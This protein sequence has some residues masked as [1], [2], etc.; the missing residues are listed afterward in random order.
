MSGMNVKESILKNQL[1]LLRHKRRRIQQQLKELK[2]KRSRK[3]LKPNKKEVVKNGKRKVVSDFYK[4]RLDRGR[5]SRKFK[6]K[7]NVYTVNFRA[8]PSDSNFVRRLLSQMLKEVKERMQC[9]PN[10]Y[11][12]LNIRHPSLDSDV[13]YEF[14]QSKNLNESTILT[15]IEGVQQS[16]KE[17]TITD[18]SAEF[19]L[20]HVKYPQGSG[21]QSAKHLHSNKVMFKRRKRS[22]LKI[23]NGNDSLCLPRAIVVAR[24][25]SQKPQDNMKLGEWKKKWDRIKRIDVLSPQ[26]KKEAL[27]LMKLANCDPDLPCGPAEWDKLQNI[28]APEYRLK[29]FQFKACSRLKLE[30]MY[31][32]KGDGVCLN[33]LLDK[34]HY[35][36]ILSM[37][38][39]T[40][41][42]Y[43]CN[44]CD[45][46]YAHIEDHRVKCPH[47]C[48]FCLADCPCP[49]DGSSIHC[50]QC[51]GYFKSRNCYQRH[52]QTYSNKT[53]ANVCSLMDRCPDCQTWMSKKLLAHHKCGQNK[54]CRICRK[55]VDREHQCF[56]QVKSVPK[57]RKQLQ[58]YIYFDFECTQENGIHVPNLCVAHRVCQ[59][60]DHLPVDQTCSHCDF[61]GGRRHLFRG[62]DTLTQFMEWLFQSQTHPTQKNQC[63]LLHKDAIVIAHNFKGYDGQ[64]ILN[65]LV[66]TSCVTP[67]VIMNGTKILSMQVL[68]LKFIDSYNYL[69]F[70]LSKMPSAFGFEELK[71][72]YFPHFFNT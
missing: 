19:E 52:L 72:G 41:N 34:D 66:H 36:T 12:R 49:A 22:L 2:E 5:K 47:L 42:P 45:V 33:I 3:E 7:Q 54:W 8:L 50:S 1:L 62:S 56:V 6:V 67:T 38:G 16:K 28:L 71:K 69:P 32:G 37:P 24:L 51:N 13:W 39:L 29:I 55:M 57:E 27:E 64:F 10:D 11:L 14:T 63:L 68:G 65:Y 18:G 35:D 60:C 20:F 26:Q 70:A 17:F 31:R 25:H 23:E 9:N 40:E 4:I 61:L 58:L 30:V 59:H 15:K 46:G 53:D 21:G 48:S 43:Y 44:Y